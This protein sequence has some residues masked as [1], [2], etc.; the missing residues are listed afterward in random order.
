MMAST[1]RTSTGTSGAMNG[2]AANGAANTKSAFNKSTSSNSSSSS[3]K[4]NSTHMK[5]MESLLNDLQS[6]MKSKKYSD[7]SSTL[8]KLKLGLIHFQLLPPFNPHDTDTT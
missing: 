6:H 3:N 5:Q 1:L 2:A 7:A 4:D 8:T